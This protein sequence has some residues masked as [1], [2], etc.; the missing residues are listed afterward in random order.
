M[1]RVMG[2]K[3]MKY[4]K[5]GSEDDPK[6]VKDSA[7]EIVIECGICGRT[8][9]IHKVSIGKRHDLFFYIDKLRAKILEHGDIAIEARGDL[10]PKMLIIAGNVIL[11]GKLAQIESVD[12]A[13]A[14][15]GN[16]KIVA[17]ETM[18]VKGQNV[19]IP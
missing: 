17:T 13:Y 10:I 12:V 11:K 1:S 2:K 18:V 9:K 15:D 7:I 3:A 19:R 8:T 14:L 5:C 4:P 16:G 6:V